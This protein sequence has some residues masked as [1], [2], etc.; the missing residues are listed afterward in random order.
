[1]QT[2]SRQT[3]L[4]DLGGCTGRLRS[5]QVLGEQHALRVGWARLDA[6]M[7]AAEARAFWYTEELNIIF[8]RGQAIRTYCGRSLFPIRKVVKLRRHEAM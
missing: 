8:K 3:L 4:F 2:K 1:M 7:V 5:C 6:V